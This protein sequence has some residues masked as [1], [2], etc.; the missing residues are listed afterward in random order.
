MRHKQPLTPFLLRLAR[1]D[2]AVTFLRHG[3]SCPAAVCSLARPAFAEACLQH[4]IQSRGPGSS[5]PPTYLLRCRQPE[6]AVAR[7]ESG[8]SPSTLK[9]SWPSIGCCDLDVFQNCQA[10]VACYTFTVAW[11]HCI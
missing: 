1:W 5:H 9:Q 3:G 6:D 8:E 11:G 2:S 7:A 10:N 4:G